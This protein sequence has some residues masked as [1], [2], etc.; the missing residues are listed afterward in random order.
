MTFTQHERDRH[1]IAIDASVNG[2]RCARILIDATPTV[3]ERREEDTTSHGEIVRV[4]HLTAPLD[5]TP[6]SHPGKRYAVTPT[7]ADISSAFPVSH[8]LL[9]RQVCASLAAVSYFVG[10]V[11]PGLNSVLSALSVNLAASAVSDD[12]VVFSVLKYDSRFGLFE[13]S[14]DGPIQG[15]LEAFVRQPPNDGPSMREIAA[16][17][18]PSEFA[19]SRSLVIGGSRG[20][21]GLTTKILAAG[22]GDVV[23]TYASGSDDARRVRDET[24][25]C[26]TSTC[27]T[28]QL[29]LRTEGFDSMTFDRDRVDA[30]YF[31]ATPKIFKRS[32]FVFNPEW[33]QEFTYFYV[34]KFYE[35]CVYLEAA[36][37]PKAVRVYF[38]SSSAVQDRPKGLAEYAMAK[39]AAEVLIEDINRSFK[40]VV[41]VCSRLPR[42]NTDQTASIVSVESAS[43]LETLLPMIRLMNR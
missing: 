34:Q 32:S 19:G 4:D 10:M 18:R 25:K 14:F 40:K 41:V 5:H 3:A 7:S 21:G 20:L 6:E 38:P 16:L 24:N 28:L 9:G 30:V 23:F 36:A 1:R 29:D 35:L 42:L 31:F 12:A 33:F 13:I 11:C 27:E 26:L 15:S 17:V 8:R 2:M 39:A 22:G 43:N 37:T